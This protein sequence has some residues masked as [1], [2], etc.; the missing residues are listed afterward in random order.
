MY[1]ITE[2]VYLHF[3]FVRC[4]GVGV[5]VDFDVDV[6][7]VPGRRGVREEIRRYTTNCN[8]IYI[9]IYKGWI[10][11]Y[12]NFDSDFDEFRSVR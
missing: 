2:V 11:I 7:C 12:S 10:S 3:L 9:Y 4:V 8:D 1:P 5:G 6:L